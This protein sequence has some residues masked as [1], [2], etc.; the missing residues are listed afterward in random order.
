MFPEEKKHVFPHTCVK[1]TKKCEIL[2]PNISRNILSYSL[3][4][5]LQKLPRFCRSANLP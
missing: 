3:K 5:N 4:I 1:E 2:H